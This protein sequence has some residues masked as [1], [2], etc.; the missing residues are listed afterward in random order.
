[1]HTLGTAGSLAAI[2]LSVAACGSPAPNGPAYVAPTSAAHNPAIANQDGV[3]TP[4]QAFGNAC[5]QGSAA[6]SAASQPVATA[7]TANPT[8]ST[9]TQLVSKA[10]LTDTF[11]HDKEMTVFAP[12][13]D[14]FTQLQQRMGADPYNALVNNKV[15]LTRLLEYHVLVHRYDEAG[16]VN[17]GE[18]SSLQGGSLHI[19]GT[20]DALTIGDNTT[21]LGHVQCGNLPTANA[22]VFILN[23]VLLPD[24]PGSH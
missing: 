8:L 12:S 1:M 21:Q 10:G 19:Q 9:F 16:L 14:A 23:T 3:T 5:S 2:V 24:Y 13:N 15:E 4:D 18:V 7:L 17:A 20:G 11:N 22:T 6:G